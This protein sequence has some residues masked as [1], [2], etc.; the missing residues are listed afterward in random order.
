MNDSGEPAP[1]MQVSILVFS[2]F[3]MNKTGILPA[4]ERENR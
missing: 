4:L 2:G 3:E 1:E